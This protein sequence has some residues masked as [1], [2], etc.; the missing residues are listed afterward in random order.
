MLT[1]HPLTILFVI[2][3]PT[4]FSSLQLAGASNQPNFSKGSNDTLLEIE[5][6][7][8]LD[9]DRDVKTTMINAGLGYHFFDNWGLYGMLVLAENKGDSVKENNF[10]RIN[11]DSVGLGASVMLRCQM[12]TLDKFSLF[13]DA[14][15]GPIYY[16]HKFPPQGTQWNILSRFGGG[17][18]YQINTDSTFHFG[19]RFLHISNG[20]GLADDNPSINSQGVFMSLKFIF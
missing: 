1:D 16:D 2:F 8:A 20:R 19:S 15:V 11:A 6:Y 9:F 12:L 4:F 10:E 14:S 18:S 3:F 7:T 13:A 17:I 5:H